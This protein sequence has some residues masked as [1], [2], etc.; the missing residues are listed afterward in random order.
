MKKTNGQAESGTERSARLRRKVPPGG[1]IQQVAQ[2]EGLPAR[3]GAGDAFQRLADVAPL[4]VWRADPHGHMTYVNTQWTIFTGRSRERELGMGWTEVI[5]QEDAAAALDTYRAAVGAHQSFKLEFRMRHGNG[6]YHHVLV[7]GNPVFVRKKLVEYVGTA[8]DVSSRKRNQEALRDS[9]SRYREL[10]DSIVDVFCALD[11]DCHFIYWNRACAK[12]TGRTATEVIGRSLYDLFPDVRGTEVDALLHRVLS[13]GKPDSVEVEVP[14]RGRT[15]HF[16][17]LTYPS[18][19]GVSVI[20]K[21]IT[22]HWIA[23][24]AMEASEAKYRGVF[25]NANDAIVIFEPRTERILEANTRALELYG[26]S[27]EE[28]LGMSLKKITM[29]VARGEKQ[30]EQ[31]LQAGSFTD[32]ETVQFRKD[33]SPISIS[34][35]AS[36]IE[37]RGEPAILS[38]NRDVSRFLSAEEIV[39][40]QQSVLQ[41]LLASTDDIVFMQDR[42]GRYLFYNGSPRYGLSLD[43]VRGKT[44]YDFHEP[45]IARKMMERIYQVITTGRSVSS[46]SRV[47]WSGETIWFLDQHSPVRNG[48]G[49][50]ISVVTISRNITE[51]KRAEE[52]LRRSEERY[53]AFIE[54]SSDG[55]WRF[56]TVKPILTTLPVEEQVNQIFEYGYLA[57]CNEAML[58]M[59][60]EASAEAVVGAPVGLVISRS[61]RQNIEG[62]RTFVE[63]GYRLT[64]AESREVAPDG[65]VRYFLN[66]L[67]GMVEEGALVR[68]WGSRRDI[69]SR[70]QVERQIRLLA[71]TITSTKDC[72]T[73]TDLDQRILFVND[74]LLATYGY[75]EEELVGEPLSKL[76]SPAMSN[77]VSE[78]IIPS[79]LRGGWYGEVLDRRKDGTDVPL[80][81]WTSVVRNDEGEP[82][83][84]VGVARDITERKRMEE[85]LRQSEA[86]LRRLTDTMRDIVTQTDADGRIQYV[87]PSHRQVLGYTLEETLGRPIFQRIHPEDLRS[88]QE[89]FAAA[90]A[91][92]TGGRLEF[93]YRH[94]DGHYLWLESVGNLLFDSR[95]EVVGAV[96]GTRDVTERK[97]VEEQITNSL[98]EKEVLLKEIHHRVKNNL[99]VISSLLNL[100]SEHVVDDEIRRVLKESQNRVRSMAIIHQR[101]YQSGNLAEVNFAGYIKELCSQLLRSYGAASRGVSLETDVEDIGLGVDKAIPC[102]I[103]LNELVS[104]AL[105]YAFPTAGGGLLTV[106]LHARE[107]NIRLVVAD[108]GAGMP[109][110]LDYQTSESLG[111]KLVNMLVDQ[112]AGTLTQTENGSSV[113]GR[114]GTRWTISFSRI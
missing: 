20:A 6:D 10:A 83:A 32:F 35:N 78:Q 70:K 106:Q 18:K 47:E 30:I 109:S 89:A 16:E 7:T 105:K 29:D 86:R 50:V 64:D 17:I 9:V 66:T 1:K 58:V 13:S 93:R 4:L 110:A 85:A 46:E 81:I 15:T 55:I 37:F 97:Q 82:V 107:R 31:T 22:E 91:H 80:E 24:R 73:I 79:T 2:R 112:I 8:V 41:H 38:I 56:E 65:E 52:K 3:A 39:R 77:E 99:Q 87:S 75:S 114:P 88:A 90:I 33:G 92:R 103:I 71:Q 61:D 54:Q 34:V 27:R 5:H 49:E 45:T 104:N 48:H 67:L 96:F 21:D 94:A 101:L 14:L 84:M 28:F 23:E 60:R 43:E 57:E 19:S 74:A 98:R 102:G 51:R 63:S 44:P 36:V 11:K 26:F 76:R 100:Q 95:G 108:D 25:E 68:I 42:D 53:R 62:F 69:T 72:I 12:A 59:L 113:D 40:N 111:L